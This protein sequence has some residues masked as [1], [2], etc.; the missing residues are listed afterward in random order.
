LPHESCAIILTKNWHGVEHKTDLASGTKAGAKPRAPS[1]AKLGALVGSFN[2]SIRSFLCNLAEGESKTA[3]RYFLYLDAAIADFF[4][5]GNNKNAYEVYRLFLDIYHIDYG[6]KGSFLDLLDAMKS[7]EENISTMNDHQRDHYVHS[8]NV[9]LLGLYIYHAN[10]NYREFFAA[11]I[12]TRCN[13]PHYS[14]LDEEFL[15]C[16][17]ITAL[18]HDI[19][20]PLEIISNQIKKYVRFVSDV[21]S[22]APDARPFVDFMDFHALDSIHLSKPELIS[23]S[24]FVQESTLAV[25][26]AHVKPNDAKQASIKPTNILAYNLHQSFGLDVGEI[27]ALIQG[28]LRKMQENNFMDHGFFSAII[29]LKWYG[30]L[31]QQSHSPTTLLF[32][33]IALASESMLLHNYYAGTLMKPPHKLGALSPK[34]HALAYLLILCDE[35]QEWNRKIFGK[36][37]QKELLFVNNSEVAANEDTLEIKYITSSGIFPDNFATLRRAALYKRLQ[38]EPVFSQGIKLYAETVPGFYAENSLDY[39]VAPR[40]L[41]DHLERLAQMIHED[42]ISKQLERHPEQNLEYESWDS[43]PPSMKYSNVRQA[44]S[45]PDK[46]SKIR[47]YLKEKDSSKDDAQDGT[48]DAIAEGVAAEEVEAFSEQELEFLAQYE[49]ELWVTER[50]ESGWTF[51]AVKDT[52]KQISPYL[53][54]YHELSEEIKELDRDT[55]RNIISLVN[56]VGYGVYRARETVE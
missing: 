50:T 56:A 4:A 53:V 29:V 54:P 23:L 47:C 30:E 13:K 34:D 33:E 1:R 17:G 14:S 25:G 7:Y 37:D 48:Q 45:I 6:K 43:L 46:L 19:G 32:N 41:I 8:V 5:L 9:F 12:N 21:S 15:F 28:Y 10:S 16:W 2:E 18:F 35:S 49:H 40:L 27:D 36:R 51:G 11:Q 22:G 20:Y 44:A 42:Y 31:L 26:H 24:E 52:E 39:L 38:V 55:I 3:S